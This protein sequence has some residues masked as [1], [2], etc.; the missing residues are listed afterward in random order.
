[1][2]VGSNEGKDVNV[3]DGK[4]TSEIVFV[5]E[6]TIPHL[7]LVKELGDSVAEF[8]DPLLFKEYGSN[9]VFVVQFIRPA[10]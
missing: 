1:V 8:F 4:G 3:S 10:S 2:V 5:F 6:I 9:N 7:Q